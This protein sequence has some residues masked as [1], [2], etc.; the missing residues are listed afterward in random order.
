MKKLLL[1]AVLILFSYFI[2]Y[3]NSYNPAIVEGIARQI[4]REVVNY[5]QEHDFSQPYTEEHYRPMINEMGQI[6]LRYNNQLIKKPEYKI[7]FSSIEIRGDPIVNNKPQWVFV[8]L[9]FM[10]DQWNLRIRVKGNNER[11]I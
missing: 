8:E 1:I 10:A 6:I 2:V 11:E 5:I 4:M 9:N 3:A 7:M